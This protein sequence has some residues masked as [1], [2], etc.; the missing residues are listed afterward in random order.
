MTSIIFRP[1]TFAD[2]DDYL[3]LWNTVAWP[4]LGRDDY[5]RD[6]VLDEWQQSGW[7]PETHTQLAIAEGRLVG[8]A[9]VKDKRLAQGATAINLVVHPDFGATTLG[10]ELLAWCEAHLRRSIAAKRPS[11]PVVTRA[12][13][14]RGTIHTEQALLKG[15]YTISNHFTIRMSYAFAD[16]PTPVEPIWPEGI[17]LRPFVAERD[18]LGVYTLLRRAFPKRAQLPFEDDFK[19]WRHWNVEREKIEAWMVMVVVN[20][21]GEIIGTANCFPEVG[22]QPGFGWLG[23]LA[24]HPDYRGKG[25]ALAILYHALAEFRTRGFAGLAL[26]VDTDNP[27]GIRLYEKA[28]MRA[29]MQ[30]DL[31]E[32]TLG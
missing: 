12:F 7:S 5:T 23:N 21:A 24:V 14:R 9:E 2:L 15:G 11:V 25:I 3:H 27:A 20:T 4:I 22:D 31:Y 6:E 26:G 32:K 29:I 16:H 18:N 10:D 30:F 17:G 28:G 1:G 13:I 19:D 8:Y